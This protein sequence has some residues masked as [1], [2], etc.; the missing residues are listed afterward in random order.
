MS[1]YVINLFFFL[2]LSRSFCLDVNILRLTYFSCMVVTYTITSHLTLRDHK[3]PVI[4]KHSEKSMSTFIN[5][6]WWKHNKIFN[7]LIIHGASSIIN[8]STNDPNNGCTSYWLHLT[9]N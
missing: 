6:V 7:K 2:I 5:N 8:T 4:E 1:N 3:H 9:T